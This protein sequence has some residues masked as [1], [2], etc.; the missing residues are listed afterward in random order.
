MNYNFNVNN[1]FS[2]ILMQT[3]LEKQKIFK[4]KKNLNKHTLLTIFSYSLKK[5]A[6]RHYVLRKKEKKK[7]INLLTKNQTSKRL[8]F[9]VKFPNIKN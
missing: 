8:H 3:T 4:E 5:N 7:S 6:L 1:L 2:K 9:R